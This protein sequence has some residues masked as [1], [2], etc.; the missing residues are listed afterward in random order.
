MLLFAVYLGALSILLPV[1]GTSFGLGLA[2]QGRLFPADFGGFVVGVMICGNLSDRL[3][4][5]TVL[6]GGI[7]FYALGLALFGLAA[8]FPLALLAAVLIGAGSGSME[9]VASALAGEIYPERRAFIINAIQIAFGAGAAFGPTLA[10]YLLSAGTDWRALF[11]GLAAINIVVAAAFCFQRV[12]RTEYSAE[13]LRWSSV[14]AVLGHPVF[15]LLCL[16]QALYVGSE[17][18]F[19]S[20]MPTYFQKSLPHGEAWEGLI[21]SFFWIPMTIGR[22]AIGPALT[23]WPLTALMVVLAVGGIVSSTLAIVFFSPGPVM[24]SV[25]LT[26]LFFSGLFSLILAEAAERFQDLAGTVYGC[27]VAAGGVGGAI[28]PWLI[29]AAADTRLHL[30]G[31]L[32]LIPSMV[33]GILVIGIHLRRNHA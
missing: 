25:A 29:G 18:G 26:G 21:V 15:L 24:L 27:V 1:I 13:S 3:G 4:R 11:L 12:P 22:I 14:R 6:L 5:K 9:V 7:A 20:W 2:V 33:A 32:G 31:A 17:V 19:F 8:T 30:R 28:F 16:A 10:H 23:R